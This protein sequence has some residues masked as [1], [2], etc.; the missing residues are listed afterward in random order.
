MSNISKNIKNATRN[1]FSM[2]IEKKAVDEQ[3][4][5]MEALA[6]VMDEC[7][8]DPIVCSKLI[9]A[10]LKAKIEAEAME[11]GMFRGVGRRRKQSIEEFE[12]NE[13]L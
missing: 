8:I 3:I 6:A 9:N 13:T 4:T 5:V 7:K 2:S 11:A 10:S 12:V 1:E